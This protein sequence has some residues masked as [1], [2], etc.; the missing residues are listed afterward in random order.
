MDMIDRHLKEMTDLI[1]KQGA[2]VLQAI[3]NSAAKTVSDADARRLANKLR[4]LL[5]SE[6]A[7]E[8]R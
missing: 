6:P 5:A 4:P 7:F 1:A 2:N 8:A 3:Q